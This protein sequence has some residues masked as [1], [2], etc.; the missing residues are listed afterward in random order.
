MT[1]AWVL[2][3]TDHGSMIVNRLDYKE[4]F[5]GFIGVG[6]QLLENGAYD[7]REVDTSK[8]LLRA[9]RDY[10]G[11]GVVALDCGANVG[12]LTIE[13]AR[14]MRRWGSVVAIEAQERIFYA[15]A[16]NVALNN[17]ANA[18][19]VWAAVSDTCG[20][21]GIPEPDYT[22]GS[23]FGSLELRPRLGVE[24]IGQPLDYDKP[25]LT[26]KTLTIDSLNLPRCDLIKLD[27]EGMELEALDG[28]WITISRCRPAIMV[29]SIKIDQKKL[30]FFLKNRDYCIYPMGIN[31]LAVHADDPINKH[32][33]V[34]RIAA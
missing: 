28:A 9:L 20:E 24:D 21:L 22:T 34:G 17:C 3:N 30:G 32:L 6:C 31:V 12:V 15:L 13:W 4:Q 8:E 23:S 7:R 26:V 11:D 16:G 25:S 27:V 18:R 5:D 29:E 19:C 10:R 2:V 14:L 1:V 33:S